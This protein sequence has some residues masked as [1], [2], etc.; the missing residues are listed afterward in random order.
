MNSVS[1]LRITLKTGAN[2]FGLS[3][4]LLLVLPV[5]F[6]ELLALPESSDLIW[7]MRMIGITLIALTGNMYVVASSATDSGVMF[8]GKVMMVAATA[9]GVLTL[10]IPVSLNWFTLSYA[11]IGFGFGAT[12]ATLLVRATRSR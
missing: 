9:L 6:L 4:I 12:Y 11:G 1:A 3:A 2:V 8:S 5:L 7:S 10:T